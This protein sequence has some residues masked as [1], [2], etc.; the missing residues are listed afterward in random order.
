MAEKTTCTN[1][2][3]R[4]E[5]A[6]GDSLLEEV[7]GGEF[8]EEHPVGI[9]FCRKCGYVEQTDSPRLACPN[10]GEPRW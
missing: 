9:V 2:V 4:D 3:P 8:L 1:D 6:L 10:C 5:A 7:G